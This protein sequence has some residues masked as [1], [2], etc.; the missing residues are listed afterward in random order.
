MLLAIDIGNSSVSC[1]VFDVDSCC[2][3]LS[4]P[5]H[6]FKITT[7]SISADEYALLISSFLQLKNIYPAPVSAYSRDPSSAANISYIDC[8]AIA[9][10]VPALTDTL[11]RAAELLSGQSPFI[12]GTGIK[13]E[14]GIHIKS[15]QQ[16]GADIVANTAAAVETADAPLAILDVGTATTLTVVDKDRNILG[17]IIMPGLQVSLSALSGSAAQLIDVALRFPP[18]LVGRDSA[19][20]IQSGVLYGHVLMIDGFIRNIREQYPEL[21]ASDK[22]SL[23]ST[24]GLSDRITPYLRNK[25]TDC[26]A[27]TLLGIAK[28]YILNRNRFH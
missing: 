1:G 9:S 27:L 2:E 18:V 14:L 4:L 3:N 8:A 24:G 17:T 23:I 5:V 20:S 7:K 25:F 12:V 19:E 21:V 15:P 28:L 11:A 16:L 13:T 10:V 22:L 6:D 26:P